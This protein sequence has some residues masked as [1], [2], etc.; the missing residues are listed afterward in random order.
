VALDVFGTYGEN[1]GLVRRT[2]GGSGAAEVSDTALPGMAR[3]WM[4]D[5]MWFKLK[6]NQRDRDF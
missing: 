5:S 3:R 2:T 1:L 4:D 6:I